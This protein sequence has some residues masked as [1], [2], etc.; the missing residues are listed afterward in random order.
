VTEDRP[1]TG[2]VVIPA[3]VGEETIFTAWQEA[4]KKSFDSTDGAAESI[5]TA[6]FSIATAYGALIGLVSAKDEPG[7]IYLVIPFVFF[8]VAALAALAARTRAVPARGEIEVEA[9]RH[10]IEDTAHAK[11][12]WAWRAIVIL[13][14][15]IVWA[16]AVVAYAYGGASG[17]GKTSVLVKLGTEGRASLSSTCSGISEGLRGEL[18][19]DGDFLIL[20][21]PAGQCG[22]ATKIRVATNQV[23]AVIEEPAM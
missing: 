15:A 17:S 5:L 1:T 2:Q 21:L 10:A 14:V 3:N 7:S 20:A 8:G 23:V 6:S 16:G 22:R 19:S 11:R 9:I 13:F 12:T 4:I 18:E